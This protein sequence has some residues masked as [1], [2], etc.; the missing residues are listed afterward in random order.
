MELPSGLKYA[1]FVAKC[2]LFFGPLWFLVGWHIIWIA[3]IMVVFDRR[4]S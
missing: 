2:V 3:G 4:Q 1:L